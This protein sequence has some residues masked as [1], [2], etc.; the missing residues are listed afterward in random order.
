MPNEIQ[1]EEIKVDLAEMRVW[2]DR[3]EISL[4]MQ[5]LRL[6]M[7][8]LADPY[9]CYS[10]QELITSVRLTSLNSLHALV[11][12]VRTRLGQKYIVTVRGWGYAFTSGANGRM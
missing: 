6:L 12:R 9:R 7:V 3:A 10:N 4:S 5:E 1:F 8:F 11:N 2:L